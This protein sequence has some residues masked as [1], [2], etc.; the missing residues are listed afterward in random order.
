MSVRCTHISTCL[1]FSYYPASTLDNVCLSSYN[2]NLKRKLI[3]Q[4]YKNYHQAQN[5]QIKIFF[6][7]AILLESNAR[8]RVLVFVYIYTLVCVCVCVMR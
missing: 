8:L 3:F 2:I 1:N 5:Q 7:S 4:M 6:N